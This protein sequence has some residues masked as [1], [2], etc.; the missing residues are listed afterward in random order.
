[1][2][3]GTRDTG[4]SSSAFKDRVD[5][6]LVARLADA[7]H[8]ADARFPAARF[9]QLATD[10]LDALELKARMAHVAAALA[11]T[12]PEDFPDAAAVVGRVLD[13]VEVGARSLE[14]WELWPVADWVALAGRGH[15]GVA[16]DLL[17]RL[18]RWATGEF[19]IRPF[20]DDDP[21]GVL[22]VLSGWVDDGEEHRCRLAS[23]GTRPRL[24]W[25]PRLSST[26][27]AYAVPLLD[28]L[29]EHPS[30]YVRRSVSNHLNDLCRVDQQLG[31]EL[32]RRWAGRAA[33]HDR[34]AD[35]EWVVRR[36]LRSLVKD[37]HPEALRL[38]GHD[39]DVAVRAEELHLH[40]PTVELG[41]HAAWRLTLV[42]DDDRPHRVVLDYAVHFPRADG[43]AGR[44][45]FKWTT[46]ELGPGARR[47]L[48]R[49]HPVRPVTIRTHR[50]GPHLV[51]I[52]VNGRVVAST[53]FDLRT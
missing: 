30:D 44:K 51:E 7:L 1:M 13:Q 9:E 15:P 49:R 35:I 33:D 19:A 21:G 31:L 52:Q 45:V 32:A 25:A 50:P 12:L 2:P 39:P 16:L 24:P 36:G 8:D 40:T 6:A 18:T 41:G 3:S 20:V 46:V 23:E 34:P 11:A 4:A 14:G 38:L 47:T 5:A 43:G 28:R 42:S 53:T 27:P 37:G 17:G 48:E 10:G 26:D 22:E 29:V